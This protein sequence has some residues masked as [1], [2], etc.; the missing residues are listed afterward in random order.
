MVCY[1]FGWFVFDYDLV[2]ALLRLRCCV[3]F[4]S[5]W[6]EI[7]GCLGSNRLVSRFELGSLPLR[8]G[9]WIFARSLSSRLIRLISIERWVGW[10]LAQQVALFHGKKRNWNWISFSKQTK[11]IDTA[12][13]IL[14]WFWNVCTCVWIRFPSWMQ[15]NPFAGQQEG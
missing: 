7:F 6:V 10:N 9:S 4:G 11:K 5:I 3:T 2:A 13:G 14:T 12:I 1:S 8:I 15:I